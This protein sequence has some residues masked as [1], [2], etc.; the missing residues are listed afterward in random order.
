MYGGPAKRGGWFE[1][2]IFLEILKLVNFWSQTL[3]LG[4]L[5][6]YIVVPQM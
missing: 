2:I 4:T 1:K 5:P 3:T 6:V